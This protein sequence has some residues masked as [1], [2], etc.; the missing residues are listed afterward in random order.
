MADSILSALRMCFTFP[1]TIQR[2]F[3]LPCPTAASQLAV[4]GNGL[5]QLENVDVN[6]HLETGLMT[7]ASGERRRSRLFHSKNNTTANEKRLPTLRR[8]GREHCTAGEASINIDK[9]PGV[10]KFQDNHIE[11]KLCTSTKDPPGLAGAWIFSV[12][13]A[14]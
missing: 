13:R 10:H 3:T 11:R 9:L 4:S 14:F 6:R 2:Q 1:A 7:N 5:L 12:E 8:T